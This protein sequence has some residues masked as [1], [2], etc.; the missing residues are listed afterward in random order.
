MQ[1]RYGDLTG[2]EINGIKILKYVEGTGKSGIARRWLCECPICHKQYSIR[3][4]HIFNRKSPNCPE[5]VSLDREDLTGQRYGLLTVDNMIYPGKYKRSLCSCTCDCG[6]TGVIVQANH[7]KF[8]ETKSCGCLKSYPEEQIAMLL[9]ESNIVFER[10]KRFEDLKYKHPLRFDF[11]LPDMNLV[12]EYNGEQHYKSI[13]HYGGEEG[14]IVR[15]LRDKIKQEY[16][17]ENNI[18][19]LTIRYDEDIEEV[20]IANNIIMKR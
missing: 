13:E 5:C 10:E 2:K 11:Y 18:N 9:S 17:I 19:Y 7:L 4:D 12:I 16:C 14:Y 8:G 20:L 15:Q 3:Q 1:K 6:S